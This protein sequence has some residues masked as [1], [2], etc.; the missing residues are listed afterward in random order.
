[1]EKASLKDS[2]PVE[3]FVRISDHELHISYGEKRKNIPISNIKLLD[4]KYNKRLGSLILGGIIAPLCIV[5]YF[6]LGL[7]AREMILYLLLG[8]GLMIH[9]WRGRYMFIVE[10]NDGKKEVW[11]TFAGN[12]DLHLLIRR[13]YQIPRSPR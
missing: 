7:P 13:F 3:Y 5:A 9:G 4:Y 6:K 11:T 1:M 8:L 12:Q 2:N 10:T